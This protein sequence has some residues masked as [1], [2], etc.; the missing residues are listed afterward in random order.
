MVVGI[1]KKFNTVEMD[2]FVVMPNHFHGIIN[3]V[4]G[5]PCVCPDKNKNINEGSAET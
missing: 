3:I 1:Q 4:G 2:V 5:D